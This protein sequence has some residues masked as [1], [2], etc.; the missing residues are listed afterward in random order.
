MMMMM[1]SPLVL[2]FLTM[3]TVTT[4]AS[5]INHVGMMT[6]PNINDDT[7][8]ILSSSSSYVRSG[9]VLPSDH[10]NGIR[11]TNSDHHLHHRYTQDVKD[12]IDDD[13]DD[14]DDTQATSVVPSTIP[15]LSFVPSSSITLAVSSSIPSDQSSRTTITPST[16]MTPTSHITPTSTPLWTPPVLPPCNDSRV[17]MDTT[18]QIL[19][20]LQPQVQYSLYNKDRSTGESI[21]S[22]INPDEQMTYRPCYM[23]IRATITPLVLSSSSLLCTVVLPSTIQ[24]TI[25]SVRMKLYYY[26]ETTTTTTTDTINTTVEVV[27]DHIERTA[28]YFLYGNTNRTINTNT[29]LLNDGTYSIQSTIRIQV[30][31]SLM[32]NE[33]VTTLAVT[34][35]PTPPINFTLYPCVE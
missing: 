31:H 19:A 2:V 21:Y 13:D 15:S 10:P 14:D 35:I 4:D 17:P 24:I 22:I 3:M 9:K 32:S 26:N 34:T 7:N 12:T 23:N 16:T 25:L 30:V 20:L 5:T 11:T 1:I 27:E 28:P 6:E 29:D 8:A 18:T 33:N